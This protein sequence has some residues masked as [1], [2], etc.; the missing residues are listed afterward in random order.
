M[1]KATG[2]DV[3][4]NPGTA[5]ENHVLREVAIEIATSDFVTLIGSNGSGKSTLLRVLSGEQPATAGS[6]L[7]SGTDITNTPHHLRARYLAQ[8]F[9]DPLAGTCAELSIEENMA[10]AAKRGTTR[11]LSLAVSAKSRAQFKEHLAILGLG[12]ENR[13]HD[14]VGMLSGGQRQALCLI[15]TTLAPSQVLLLDEHTAALDPRMSAFILQ[16][17]TKLYDTFKLTVVMVTHSMHDALAVGN[18]TVMIHQGQLVLDLDKAAR[19]QAT[20]Q[21][22]FDEFSRLH[23]GI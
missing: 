6:V 11:K 13:L 9:Q 2:L 16:L 17:T 22:L 7:L 18:R 10:F 19:Q 23:A 20:P 8:V 15:M 12:L 1:I 4:F 3:I 21:F 5:L 14:Q